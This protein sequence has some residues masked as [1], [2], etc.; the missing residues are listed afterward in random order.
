MSAAQLLPACDV[1]LVAALRAALAGAA[2]PQKAPAMQVCAHRVR[3][4]T[5]HT[6]LNVTRV[7]AHEQAYMK[8]ALPFYGVSAV[9]RERV[10]RA[11]FASHPPLPSFAAWRDTALSLWRSAVK[12]EERYAA[13]A[14]LGSPEYA[15]HAASLEALPLYEELCTTGAWWDYVDTVAPRHLGGLLRAHGAGGMGATLR[16]WAGCEDMWKR[17]A[18]CIAQ[19]NLKE[20]ETDVALLYDCLALNLRGS[21]HGEEFFIQKGVGWALRQRAR[22]APAEVQRFV[23]ER[24][25]A[26][27]ALTR[28]EALKH[29]GAGADAGAGGAAAAQ[30]ATARK[31]QRRET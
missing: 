20:E 30:Q 7:C 23:R 16:A 27:S 4:S 21:R 31:R 25:D 19:L 17:R 3:S 5:L 28:R 1:A 22:C 10:L 9:T 12:R 26:V 29:V 24:G 14:L 13:L 11:A 15:T 6:R 18:A 8:S 2:D